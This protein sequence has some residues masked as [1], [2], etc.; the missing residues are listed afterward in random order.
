MQARAR[1]LLRSGVNEG[2]RHH[3][4]ELPIEKTISS[5]KGEFEAAGAPVALEK[6]QTFKKLTSVY[7]R[8]SDREGQ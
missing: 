2:P 7:S 5:D 8:L 4:L 6:L 1:P 3:L